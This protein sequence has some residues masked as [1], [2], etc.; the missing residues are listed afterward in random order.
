MARGIIAARA[1]SVT[2]WWRRKIYPQII[3]CQETGKKIAC[4]NAARNM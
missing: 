2:I 1:R 4:C 3:V